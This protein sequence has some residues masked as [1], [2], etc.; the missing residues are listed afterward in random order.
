[1]TGRHDLKGVIED[2][3]EVAMSLV[4]A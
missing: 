4:A 2:C 1:L 3:G